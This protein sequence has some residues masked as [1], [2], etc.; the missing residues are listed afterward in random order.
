M[1]ALTTPCGKCGGVHEVTFC[2]AWAEYLCVNCRALR[3][4]DEL[5]VPLVIKE[6]IAATV[7]DITAAARMVQGL[8]DRSEEG[9]DRG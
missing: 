5:R 8:E 3:N 9:A 7:R 6:T 4:N 2:P 1:E